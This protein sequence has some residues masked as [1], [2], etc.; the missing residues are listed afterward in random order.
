MAAHGD[1]V[2][3]A[4]ARVVMAAVKVVVARHRGRILRIFCAAARTACA[5]C[6]REVL[7]ARA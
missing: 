5:P 6:C 1:R 4:M 2:A 7:A 3:A